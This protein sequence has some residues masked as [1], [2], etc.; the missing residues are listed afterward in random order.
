MFR[1]QST[2]IPLNLKGYLPKRSVFPIPKVGAR[3]SSE[4]YVLLLGESK[5]SHHE[6]ESWLIPSVFISQHGENNCHSP[7]EFKRIPPSLGLSMDAGQASLG[8]PGLLDCS[9]VG[10]NHVLGGKVLFSL[11]GPAG[12]DGLGGCLPN[13]P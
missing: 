1:E 11:P 13:G 12:G 4:L 5:P 7:H 8:Y 3:Y 9:Y 10:V 6:Y 2:L